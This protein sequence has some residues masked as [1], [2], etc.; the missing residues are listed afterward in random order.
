MPLGWLREAASGNFVVKDGHQADPDSQAYSIDGEFSL[1]SSQP[2]GV[3]HS[4][5]IEN[6][7]EK[8]SIRPP[9]HSPSARVHNNPPA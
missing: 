4:D 7:H 6:S 8:A 3:I 1:Q 9:S 2:F 5:R